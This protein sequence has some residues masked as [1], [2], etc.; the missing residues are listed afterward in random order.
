MHSLQRGLLGVILIK[1]RHK[2]AVPWPTQS[3]RRSC[4]S[5]NSAS[6]LVPMDISSSRPVGLTLVIVYIFVG[7]AATVSPR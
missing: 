6:C 7:S 4:S 2:R 3:C 1:R 5:E